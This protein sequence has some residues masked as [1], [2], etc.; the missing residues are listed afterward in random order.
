MCKV[1]EPGLTSFF[2]TWTFSYPSAICCRCWG[3]V[4]LFVCFVCVCVCILS[5]DLKITCN[6]C[7]P[8]THKHTFS[9]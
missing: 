8:C 4:C 7:M 5:I 3:F 9:T 2:Y 1:I 6:T